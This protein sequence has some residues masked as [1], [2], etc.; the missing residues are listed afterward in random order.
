MDDGTPRHHGPRELL[1]RAA[2]LGHRREH[3]SLRHR[4]RA[5]VETEQVGVG[6]RAADRFA[7][8]VG[9]WRFIIGQ[10]VVLAGWIVVNVT[11]WTHHWDPYPFIL[12]NLMLS[13][14]AAY[15]G[16]IIMMS[17]NR[18]AERDRRRAEADYD[19]NQKTELEAEEILTVLR[20]QTLLIEELRGEIGG[21]RPTT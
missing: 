21:L 17:Q 13:F 20:A 7:K 2:E 4:A 14:Q 3:L 6:A 8:L 16:P 9:S 18:S 19:I 12:L 1:A 15:A 10:S 5:D 11:A